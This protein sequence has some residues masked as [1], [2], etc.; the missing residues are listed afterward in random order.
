MVGLTLIAAT[1]V[2]AKR[3][4]KAASATL[5]FNGIHWDCEDRTVRRY[6]PSTT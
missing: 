2:F 1:V 6:H 5:R 4:T 3:K